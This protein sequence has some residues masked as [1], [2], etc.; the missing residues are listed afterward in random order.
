MDFKDGESLMDFI[1]R[2]NEIRHRINT[3]PMY[4]KQGRASIS[5][6][7]CRDLLLTKAKA[8]KRFSN[9]ITIWD[10]IESNSGK[11]YEE[12]TDHL[13]RIESESRSQHDKPQVNVITQHANSHNG[14]T[15]N[16]FNMQMAPCKFFNFGNGHCKYGATCKFSHSATQRP[17][18]RENNDYGKNKRKIPNT[19]ICLNFQQGRCSRSNCPRLHVNKD[20]II[21]SKGK[22]NTLNNI[23][24]KEEKNTIKKVKFQ[25]PSSDS[26]KE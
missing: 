5:D 26:D 3:N 24:H 1:S 15:T 25:T 13:F 12:L 10:S 4:I 20:S 2:I 18:T 7:D 23:N 19:E 22:R 6:I 16:R 17:N 9:A 11:S 14:N 21:N 8:C